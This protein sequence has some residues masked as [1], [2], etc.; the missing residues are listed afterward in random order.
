MHF[1]KKNTMHF[2]KTDL[3]QRDEETLIYSVGYISNKACTIMLQ[4]ACLKYVQ[5]TD[6]RLKNNSGKLPNRMQVQRQMQFYS[7]GYMLVFFISLINF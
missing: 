1:D 7:N 2:D 5:W 6:I 4:I 3:L